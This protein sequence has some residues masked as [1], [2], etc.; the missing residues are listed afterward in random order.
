MLGITVIPPTV[1]HSNVGLGVFAART[2][3]RGGTIGAYYASLE[4]TDL[5][6]QLLSV[7]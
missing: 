6:K 5:F 2:V 1:D 4:Y 7:K 3:S